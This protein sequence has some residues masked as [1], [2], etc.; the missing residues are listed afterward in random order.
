MRS[1]VE[2]IIEKY[3]LSIHC[4]Q[5]LKIDIFNILSTARLESDFLKQ[6]VA[7]L[8]LTILERKPGT[9]RNHRSMGSACK[10][11]QNKI[12]NTERKPV[13]IPLGPAQPR[14][15]CRSSAHINTAVVKSQSRGRSA[16]FL[17]KF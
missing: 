9:K 16:I 17:R 14:L 2:F 8:S 7:H 12:H 10:E 11:T 1:I 15:S 6:S 5:I 13:I 3:N 4:F